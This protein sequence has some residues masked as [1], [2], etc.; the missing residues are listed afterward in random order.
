MQPKCLK[1]K[2]GSLRSQK[3]FQGILGHVSSLVWGEELAN[4]SHVSPCNAL[5]KGFLSEKYGDGGRS[6]GFLTVGP[7]SVSQDWRRLLLSPSPFS[8]PAFIFLFSSLEYLLV[9]ILNATN[10]EI[11]GIVYESVC[12]CI[13]KAREKKC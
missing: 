9:L 2:R 7:A 13:S 8:A 5:R 10:V 11:K 12:A 4:C 3:L 1:N 6:T